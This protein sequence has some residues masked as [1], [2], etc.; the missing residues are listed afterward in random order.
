MNAF[1]NGVTVFNE[2]NMNE[3]LALQPFSLIYEGSLFD[4][5][6]GSET[7]AYDVKDAY[8]AIRV[9]TTGVTSIMRV[10]LEID[11]EGTGQDLTLLVKDTNFNPNGSNEG[12]T[13][14]TIVVPKEFLPT[15]AAY[16]SIPV[17]LTGLTA[18]ANYW[19]IVQRVGDATNHFYLR[20]ELNQDASHP[21]Y[22]RAGGSGAWTIS[23]SI[24][25][26][27]CYGNQGPLC[28]EIYAQNGHATF[29]YSSNLLSKIYYYLPPSDGP[30]G[31]I[32]KK[33]TINYADGLVTGGSV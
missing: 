25:F 30:A 22:A 1:K 4:A 12:T 28:H 19:L 24:H 27:A 2:A 9:T 17:N 21:C 10:G 15:T 13:L 16:I 18:G 29:E 31:G 23:S 5:K 6:G 7:N 20:G 32:R 14:K 3:L 33:M 8:Y 11:S 26:L